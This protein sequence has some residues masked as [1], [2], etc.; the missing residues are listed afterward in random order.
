MR[1]DFNKIITKPYTLT[2]NGESTVVDSSPCG[3]GKTT[4]LV[5]SIVNEY[6]SQGNERWR[7]VPRMILV[8]DNDLAN[9]YVS[10]ITRKSG[11]NNLA[12]AYHTGEGGELVDSFTGEVKKLSDLKEDIC[13]TPIIVLTQARI[14][15]STIALSTVSTWVKYYPRD[16]RIVIFDETP[17]NCIIKLDILP[18]ELS[19][20]LLDCRKRIIYNCNKLNEDMG[21]YIKVLD[22]LMEA[23]TSSNSRKLNLLN[24][25]KKFELNPKKAS[26]YSS[27]DAGSLDDS[28]NFESS[29]YNYKEFVPVTRQV[30]Y[31]NYE[32]VTKVVNLLDSSSYTKK[33]FNAYLTRFV[34]VNKR[35]FV[36]LASKNSKG[37]ETRNQTYAKEMFKIG[38]YG[39]LCGTIYVNKKGLNYNVI[40]KSVDVVNALAS[41][42]GVGV[43]LDGTADLISSSLGNYDKTYTI[44]NTSGKD[45]KDLNVDLVVMDGLKGYK[46]EITKDNP[47][48]TLKRVGI[49]LGNMLI[50]EGKI[51]QNF[52]DKSSNLLIATPINNSGGSNIKFNDIIRANLDSAVIVKDK[53]N[54][55]YTKWLSDKGSNEFRDVDTYVAITNFKYPDFI[56][57]DLLLSVGRAFTSKKYRKTLELKLSVE[58]LI[59]S[60]MRTALRNWDGK[61]VTV[62]LPNNRDI[63]KQVSKIFN[64]KARHIT[65]NFTKDAKLDSK[66]LNTTSGST[67]GAMVRDTI[68]DILLK[69]KEAVSVSKIAEELGYSRCDYFTRY[70]KNSPDIIDLLEDVGI[71]YTPSRGRRVGLFELSKTKEVLETLMS[72]YGSS[73]GRLSYNIYSAVEGLYKNLTYTEGLT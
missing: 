62:Y 63:I 12:K 5:D 22:N 15:H 58:V 39:V 18:D 43:L 54:L 17:S 44:F 41:Y 53:N 50:S 34:S 11:C 8:P 67:K 35:N 70:L 59:Q 60:I 23:I 42:K 29:E 55:N 64:V 38:L 21:A 10:E 19:D 24:F 31:C 45:Y 27:Y 52:Q 33:K 61:K 2:C 65:G 7:V 1:T 13:F 37:K 40:V 66:F 14:H 48:E 72:M 71:K 20:L 6:K 26:E 16:K 47:E 9:I 56:Y 57:K 28:D 46:T 36:G 51:V 4:R 49:N 32:S 30:G 3:T 25:L 69:N 68:L 73:L